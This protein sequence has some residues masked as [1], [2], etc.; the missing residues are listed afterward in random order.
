MIE[1]ACIAVDLYPHPF[2]TIALEQGLELLELE[3]HVCYPHLALRQG[4]GCWEKHGVGVG[5]PWT[6]EKFD[7]EFS[8][9]HGVGVGH[10]STYERFDGPCCVEMRV[11][12]NLRTD[13]RFILSHN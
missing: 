5:Y 8:E 2:R 10:Q 9:K 7:E 13:T 4:P 3:V 12:K 6:S 1:Y 11:K